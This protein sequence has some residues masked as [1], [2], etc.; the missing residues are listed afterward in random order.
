M[1][2]QLTLIALFF[3]I[4]ADSAYAI[5]T[6]YR[7]QLEQSRYTDMSANDGSRN[8]HSSKSQNAI[9]KSYAALY[10]SMREAYFSLNVINTMI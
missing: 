9:Q 5:N 1:N 3:T 4:A 6:H 2:T 10:N 8:I 7:A